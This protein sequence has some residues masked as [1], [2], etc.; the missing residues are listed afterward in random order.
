MEIA[1]R[2]NNFIDDLG[3][4]EFI[5]DERKQ[6]IIDFFIKHLIDINIIHTQTE[7]EISENLLNRLLN[8]HQWRQIIDGD[9]YKFNEYDFLHQ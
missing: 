2:L 6:Q 8:H 4:D 1:R 3:R 7:I 5:N 9:N